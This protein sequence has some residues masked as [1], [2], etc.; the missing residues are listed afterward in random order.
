M[1][2]P[3]TP[4][5]MDS[6]Y[7]WPIVG[8]TLAVANFAFFNLP[9]AS[10]VV[11]TGLG[12]AGVAAVSAFGD[13]EKPYADKLKENF[14]RVVELTGVVG[15]AFKSF[16]QD[17]ASIYRGLTVWAAK[18]EAE[19]KAEA[20]A[21]VADTGVSSLGTKKMTGFGGKAPRAAANQDVTPA[22]VRERSGPSA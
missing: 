8:V 3:T 12:A 14:G 4:T 15:R 2:E 20:R 7:A 6:F 21:N 17:L 9:L 16:G 13:K 5:K 18:E 22:P 1:T 19:D 10:L 11:L